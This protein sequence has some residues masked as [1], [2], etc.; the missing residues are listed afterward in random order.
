MTLLLYIQYHT[1]RFIALTLMNFQRHPIVILILDA[2]EHTL[3]K[4]KLRN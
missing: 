4:E 1:L 2:L 3:R